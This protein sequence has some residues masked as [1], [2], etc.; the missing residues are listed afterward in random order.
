MFS[1]ALD[2]ESS[3]EVREP[4]TALG[5]AVTQMVVNQTI[6]EESL[7]EDLMTGNPEEEIGAVGLPE[8]Q[9]EAEDIMPWGRSAGEES[10]DLVN[11]SGCLKSKPWLWPAQS[12]E[13]KFM[14]ERREAIKTDRHKTGSAWYIMS[15]Y[16]LLDTWGFAVAVEC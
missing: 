5:E 13:D 14:E 15:S 9:M 8:I 10:R 6:L 7:S 11:Q 2:N 4:S 3:I 16:L 1:A 12:Q